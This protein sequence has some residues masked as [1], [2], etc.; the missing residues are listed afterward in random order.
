MSLEELSRKYKILRYKESLP[1]DSPILQQLDDTKL[2]T[3]VYNQDRK[4]D[5]E[6]K[7]YCDANRMQIIKSYTDINL[8]IKDIKFGLTVVCPTMIQLGYTTSDISNILTTVESLGAKIIILDSNFDRST[9][10]G[11]AMFATKSI[12]NQYD[13]E[14]NAFKT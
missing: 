12:F 10:S 5:E 8:M 1:K 2:P 3:V 13:Y 7:R 11:K 4:A 9:S 6:I 14:S